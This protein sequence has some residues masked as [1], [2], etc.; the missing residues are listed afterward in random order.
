MIA[1]VGELL[2]LDNV[3]SESQ[4]KE[5]YQRQRILGGRLG[6]NLLELGFIHENEMTQY[7]SKQTNIPAIP[8]G[9][10]DNIPP[11]VISVLPKKIAVD[12]KVV[13]FKKEHY[14]LH[15][16]MIDPLDLSA[17]DTLSFITGC[18]VKF[19]IATEARIYYA[20]DK[21]YNL[22]RNFRY[23][24]LIRSLSDN[25]SPSVVSTSVVEKELV[26]KKHKTDIIQLNKEKFLKSD[27][28]REILSLF[29]EQLANFCERIILFIVDRM[30]LLFWD[31]FEEFIGGKK[32]EIL[33][34]DF[35]K[36]S[37]L[38]SY[39][40]STK[41][42]HGVLERTEENRRLIGAIGDLFPPDVVILPVVIGKNKTAIAYG[43]N[44]LSGKKIEDVEDIKRLHLV[45]L[46]AVKI[47]FLQQK[48][49]EI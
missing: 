17:V 1:K 46:Y 3:V 32:G 39:I 28:R 47:Y 30:N 48:I 40:N 42:F 20:L 7:L 19:Y 14:K 23:Y 36:P 44:L 49:K 25:N 11:H 26:A 34:F 31:D 38:K 16:A 18:T 15:V 2:L 12:Y 8:S 5:A 41:M 43:D 33:N 45:A 37:F 9:A 22:S 13:P 29:L 35:N 24:N 6:T 4:L 27:T 21:Y 10:L